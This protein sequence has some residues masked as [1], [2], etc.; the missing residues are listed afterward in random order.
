[1]W[2]HPSVAAL[3]AGSEFEYRAVKFS[4]LVKAGFSPY[5]AWIASAYFVE[6]VKGNFA[7]FACAASH[8]VHHGLI[9]LDVMRKFYKEGFLFAD[10]SSNVNAISYKAVRSICGEPEYDLKDNVSTIKAFLMKQGGVKT[11]GEGWE[12][13]Y[14]RIGTR[15]LFKVCEAL[16][17][18]FK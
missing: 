16:E 9:P 5:V 7:L 8:D 14:S 18:A 12:K 1:L 3:R 6:N 10:K 17:E 13:S 4:E 11:V 2:T 15:E